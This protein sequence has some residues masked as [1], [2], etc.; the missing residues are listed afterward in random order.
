MTTISVLLE[1]LEEC[2][3][4]DVI[5]VYVLEPIFKL[6]K[7]KA[8]DILSIS[9]STCTE[10][11][12]LYTPCNVAD[13]VDTNPELYD[14]EINFFTKLFEEFSE[15]IIMDINT[16]E[17]TD[18]ELYPESVDCSMRIRQLFTLINLKV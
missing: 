13:W 14:T 12:E 5:P 16:L 17:H 4:L 9:H 11:C 7:P 8:S 3:V 1:F 6:L 2:M 18:Q 10:C 15:Y